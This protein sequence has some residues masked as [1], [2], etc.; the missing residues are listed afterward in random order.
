MYM[1]IT[2]GKWNGNPLG[3]QRLLSRLGNIKIYI[4]VVCCIHPG[5]AD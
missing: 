4:P 1:D 5:A 2:L 3:I